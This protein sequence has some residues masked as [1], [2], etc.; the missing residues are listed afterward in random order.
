MDIA[1][2]EVLDRGN[3]DPLIVISYPPLGFTFAAGLYESILT[4]TCNSETP[5]AMGT[6]PNSFLI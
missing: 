3:P 6:N 4:P 5:L 1:S 2:L